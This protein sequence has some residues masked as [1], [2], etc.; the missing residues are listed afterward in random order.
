MQV[1]TKS[2]NGPSQHP[3]ATDKYAT[4][5][6]LNILGFF[7][8]SKFKPSLAKRKTIQL[9]FLAIALI[10]ISAL[11]NHRFYYFSDAYIF[12]DDAMGGDQRVKATSSNQIESANPSIPRGE[13][14]DNLKSVSD[15]DQQQIPRNRT[16]TIGHVSLPFLALKPKSPACA[17]FFSRMAAPGT[18]FLNSS[19][20]SESGQTVNIPQRIFFVHYNKRLENPRYLCAAESAARQNPMHIVT[21]YVKNRMQFEASIAR[22]RRVLGTQ[23]SDRVV[24]RELDYAD[25]FSETP[26][27]GWWANRTYERSAWVDQ[28][29]GN[30]FR[31]SRLWK[32]GGVYLDMDIISLNPVGAMGRS[33]AMQDSKRM[34]NAYFSMRRYDPF[35]KT[36]MTEFTTTFDGYSWFAQSNICPIP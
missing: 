5:F 11:L 26:L 25:A 20:V 36:L 4:L 15:T 16:T 8:L 27:Q 34:N 32:D 18:H 33:I 28:N 7:S 19:G 21:L 12:A 23:M 31:L 6:V 29:L 13:K 10:G 22:W 17:H 14:S 9:C 1:K 2:A 24:T 35:M 30:A 3:A